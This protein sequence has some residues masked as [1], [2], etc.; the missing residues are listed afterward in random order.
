MN[1]IEIFERVRETYL[2]CSSYA[3]CGVVEFDDGPQ[4]KQHIEFKTEFIRPDYFTFEWQD[5]GPRRGKSEGFSSLWSYGAKTI[6]RLDTNKVVEEEQTNLRLAIAGATG[7]SAGAAH[8]VPPLLLDELQVNSRHLFQLTDLSIVRQE[9]LEAVQCYVLRGSL[10]KDGD[11]LL[12]VSAADFHLVR[13]H[14]NKAWTAEESK[15]EHDALISNKELFAKL[16]EKGIAPPA[17]IKH[18]DGHFVTEYT[19]KSVLLNAA[20]DRLPQ[21][22]C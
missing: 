18:R 8:I 7:C 16:V 3:D 17:E 1:A 13:V 10:F 20:I 9:V 14:S 22:S 12:W 19:Y 11:H 5:Y 4:K 21:P 2:K 6:L 15:N